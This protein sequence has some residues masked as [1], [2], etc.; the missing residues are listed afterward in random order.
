MPWQFDV[1]SILKKKGVL[2]LR[3]F[4]PR[5]PLGLTTSSTEALRLR[6]KMMSRWIRQKGLQK[7]QPP[8]FFKAN[9]T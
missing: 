6:V 1:I 9:E 7:E 8:V 3:A 5:G 2:T 4:R